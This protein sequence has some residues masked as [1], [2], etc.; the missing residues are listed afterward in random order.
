VRASERARA[1]KPCC[2]P[3]PLPLPGGG[4]LITA[5]DISQRRAGRRSLPVCLINGNFLII[6]HEPSSC[7]AAP[8]RSTPDYAPHTGLPPSWPNPPPLPVFPGFAAGCGGR[9]I[10]GCRYS[11]ADGGRSVDRFSERY[12][13]YPAR[14]PLPLTPPPSPAAA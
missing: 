9:S 1:E 10:I 4:S 5:R 13:G 14:I 12:L 7:R 2:L 6:G 11:S 3:H 8:A